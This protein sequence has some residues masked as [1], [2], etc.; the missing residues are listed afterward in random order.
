MFS[1]ITEVHLPVRFHPDICS[2]FCVMSL[3]HERGC[4]ADCHDALHLILSAVRM[5]SKKQ[6]LALL[7]LFTLYVLLGAALFHHIESNLEVERRVQK[8]HERLEVQGEC[9]SGL[10]E[11]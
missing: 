7:T 9:L 11:V 8:R 5:M 3:Q 10:R 4:V 1:E 6:W 2:A